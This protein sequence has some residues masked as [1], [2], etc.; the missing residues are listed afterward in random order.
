MIVVWFCAVFDVWWVAF[1]LAFWMGFDF[2][3]G[4][5]WVCLRVWKLLFMIFICL[6]H[7]CCLCCFVFGFVGLGFGDFKLVLYLCW[8]FALM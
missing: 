1:L 7:L 2:A 3:A 4:F 8:L 6:L 5:V